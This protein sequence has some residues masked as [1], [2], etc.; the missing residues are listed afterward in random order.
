M[1]QKKVQKKE[2]DANVQ[3]HN[4]LL[5]KEDLKEVKGPFGFSKQFLV[6]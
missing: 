5:W 3:L 1:Q 4:E 6:P 2:F